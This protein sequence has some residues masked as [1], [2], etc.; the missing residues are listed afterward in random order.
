MKRVARSVIP[1]LCGMIGAGTALGQRGSGDW[2][3]NGFDA[4][5]SSWVRTDG[6]ISV[7]SM[8]K[9]GFTVVWTVKPENGPRQL[10]TLTPPSLLDFYIGY[11]GFRAL[12][13]F[14]ASSN[15]VIAVDTDLGRIEWEKNFG[16]ASSSG[17]LQ[18][19]GGLTASV[20]RP[21]IMAYPPT[22]F[23]T[24]VGRGT[25]AKSGVGQPEQG[26]VTLRPMTE[27]RPPVPPRRPPTAAPTV[28]PGAPPAAA[29]NPFAPRIQWAMALAGDGKL[30]SMYVSNGTEPNPAVPF[31]PP[32]AN[33][34]GLIAIDNFAYVSTINSC[35]GVDNGVWALD[36]G[37]SKVTN[38]K[39][40]GNV[41]GTAGPA[42]APNGM[43]YAAAGSELTALAAKT[44]QASGSYKTGGATFTSSPV[45]LEF[46]GKDLVAAATNDGR[47][48]LVDGASLSSAVEVSAP[49]S[50]ANY[51]TGALAS[52]MDVSGKRWILAPAAG[53]GATGFASDG[54]VKDG[55]IVAFE[56]VE[57]NGKPSLK[58]AWMSRNLVSPLTP[59]VVNG[60][61]FALSS[62]EFRSSDPKMSAAERAK[63]SKNAVLYALELTTGKELWNSGTS[64]RSFVH[65]GGLSEGGSRVYVAGFDGTQYAFSFPME[66]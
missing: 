11:K 52:A 3:T 22:A 18:C 1:V 4:Q 28:M 5:R 43:L 58:P 40:S 13:F 10:N 21:T 61:V 20:T 48:H 56:V 65:S 7:D 6:K 51:D 34:Q 2:M 9:P 26:A 24:G 35:G 66:H 42:F 27:Q 46:K 15:R 14:G 30:H 45:V 49:F 23:G 16:G 60:V 33:A 19:P 54:D 50:S 8:S 31:I 47:L 37:T 41:A 44:L 29:P 38:W 59:I 32:N 55:S 17:T 36:L 57:K 63:R 53:P 12:G 64:I 25:P 62:G 39:S